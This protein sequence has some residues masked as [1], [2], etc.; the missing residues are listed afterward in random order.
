M[1]R[2]PNK[3]PISVNT[4]EEHSYGHDS[5]LVEADIKSFAVALW[6][7]NI[8]VVYWGHIRLVSTY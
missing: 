6:N 1:H 7:P 4:T 3:L 8:T 5:S 2:C